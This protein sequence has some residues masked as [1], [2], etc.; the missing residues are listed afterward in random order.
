MQSRHSQLLIT[1]ALSLFTCAC[2]G[3]ITNQSLAIGWYING[4]FGLAHYHQSKISG[5][6]NDT[7]NALT[8]DAGVGYNHLFKQNWLWNAEG[9]YH[10][11]GHWK[12]A[13]QNSKRLF[14]FSA[15]GG[16]GRQINPRVATWLTL[17]LSAVRGPKF[18]VHPTFGIVGRY[19]YAGNL[20]VRGSILRTQDVMQGITTFTM[21]FGYSW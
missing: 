8:L 1:L 18:N 5:H 14:A 20:T 19:A 9:A 10:D 7:E 11:Y 12:D 21:G 2:H 4:N 17:G 15:L 3:A 13:Q 6:G 16:L